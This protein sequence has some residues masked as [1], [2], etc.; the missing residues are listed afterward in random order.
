[1][2]YLIF[3]KILHFQTRYFRFTFNFVSFQISAMGRF[4]HK[5][6]FHIPSPV[7]IYPLKSVL[8]YPI[9]CCIYPIQSFTS[10]LN[11]TYPQ[12]KSIIILN[13]PTSPTS[14][15]YPVPTSPLMF[16]VLVCCT[17]IQLL[18]SFQIFIH[19]N[20]LEITL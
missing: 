20:H 10:T 6:D 19:F 18:N 14:P 5:S 1:M 9:I 15:T 16:Y 2:I 13:Y 17:T 12:I 7:Q 8:I 4:I 3:P 11:P